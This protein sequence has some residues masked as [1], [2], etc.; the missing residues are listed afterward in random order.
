MLRLCRICRFWKQSCLQPDSRTKLLAAV[1]PQRRA[2]LPPAVSKQQQHPTLPCLVILLAVT[3]RFP[4]RAWSSSRQ[5]T[6]LSVG[7]GSQDRPSGK[8]T[9]SHGLD[10]D[11]TLHTERSGCFCASAMCWS[12]LPVLFFQSFCLHDVIHICLFCQ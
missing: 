6:A 10:P 2:P 12:Q 11:R 1:S 7:F 4:S 5:R 3:N 8:G 9:H